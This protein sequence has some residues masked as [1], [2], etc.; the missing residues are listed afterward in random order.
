M[1]K[2]TRTLSKQNQIAMVGSGSSPDTSLAASDDSTLSSRLGS[3][4]SRFSNKRASTS[5]VS[6][7]KVMQVVLRLR[8]YPGELLLVSW[9]SVKPP[10][11]S[12]RF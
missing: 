4:I 6:E 3:I 5:S 10:C 7:N 1:F 8:W 12:W 11:F 9:Q 2:F